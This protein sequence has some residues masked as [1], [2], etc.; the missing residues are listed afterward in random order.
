MGKTSHAE[1]LSKT[2]LKSK[3]AGPHSPSPSPSQWAVLPGLVSSL[4]LLSAL[5]PVSASEHPRGRR[6]RLNALIV[7]VTEAPQ[8]P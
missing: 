4:S 6:V 1:A 3:L 5:P 8:T 2:S 7:R